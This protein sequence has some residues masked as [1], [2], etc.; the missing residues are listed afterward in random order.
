ME[1]PVMAEINDVESGGQGLTVGP[2][3]RRNGAA[4]DRWELAR[5]LSAVARGLQAEP[6]VQATVL[7]IVHAAVEAVA[8]ADHAGITLMRG[9]VA[10]SPAVTDGVV[11][12]IDELQYE[13]RQGPC[14][15]AIREQ[16]IIDSADLAGDDRWAG[17]GLRAAAL[18]V[19]SM[20]A[21]PLSVPGRELG[22]VNLYARRAGAF[23]EDDKQIA[24]LVASHAAIALQA[25]QQQ[26]DLRTAMDTR[27][28]I[29]QAQ[30]ILMERGK[31]TAEQ[32]F[33]ELARLSQTLN[34]KVRDIAWALATTGGPPDPVD[35]RSHPPG[36]SRPMVAPRRPAEE[37]PVRRV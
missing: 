3:Y 7:R 21:V 9:G 2:T 18:G 36:P 33:T 34:V 26:Q 20:L 12:R 30:G 35:H 15:Q 6:D 19:A 10:T 4:V 16:A 24:V 28:L 8:G 5:A 22:A 23:D 27:N 14:L 17:F 32:A 29:G 13:L 25:R 37:L 1:V 11:T 31:I